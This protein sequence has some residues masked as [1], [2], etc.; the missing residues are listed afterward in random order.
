MEIQ[1]TFILNNF[2][3]LRFDEK[4]HKYSVGTHNIKLSVSGIIKKFVKQV[5][6]SQKA[7]DKDLRL[8]LE[9]GTTQKEWDTKKDKACEL[10]TRVHLFGEVYPLNKK[11]IP[12]DGFEKAIVKFWNDLPDFIVPVV[13]EI[14]MY[15]KKYM[16]AGTA[17][18]LLYNTK[19]DT[20][21]IGDYKTNEK[22]FSNFKGK[23]LLFPFQNLL[24]T[25]FNKYQIQL[26]LYQILFEQIG[27]KVSSRKLVWLK[28]EGYY[29]MYDTE[30]L[31]PILKKYLKNN[32]L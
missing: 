1:K 24:E 20:Y 14:Q 26:S 32:K 22:L 29:E 19:T 11:L 8:G 23:K 6:F 15:H 10:G 25:N 13:L 28:P 2:K 4:N 30:D 9:K 7:I 17:D 21:I 18:I 5:D 31:T 3:D 27:L 16:F 12:S